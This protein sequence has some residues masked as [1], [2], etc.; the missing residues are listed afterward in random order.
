MK[1]GRILALLLSLSMVCAAL[2]GGTVRAVEGSGDEEGGKTEGMVYHKTAEANGDGTYTI[3]LETYATGDKIITEGEKDKPADIVLVLD[4]SGSMDENM[5][6]YGFREYSRKDNE[7]YYRLRHNNGSQNLYYKTEDGSYISVSVVYKDHYGYEMITNGR[8]NSSG[9]WG[10]QYT[11]YWNNQNNL[12]ARVNGKYQQVTVKRERNGGIFGEY[13]Y[14]YTLPDGTVI[15]RSSG[16]DGNPSFSNIDGNRLYLAVADESQ[17][18]YTYTYTDET[19]KTTEIEISTGKDTTPNTVFYERYM[20]G[21]TKKLEALKTAVTGFVNSVAAKTAGEDGELGTADDVD[22]RIAVVGF[23]SESGY[24]NNT[25]LLSIAGNNSQVGSSGEN[26]GVK[27]GSIEDSHYTQV[28]QD[29][30]TE[31]GRDMVDKAVDALAANGATKSDLGME[32]AK[33]ILEKNPVPDGKER[34]RVVIFFTDGKPTSSNTF[35]TTVA[36][37]TIGYA[38]AI[39]NAGAQVYSVGIFDGADATD[40]GKEPG[41]GWNI[42]DADK[43]NWFMQNVSSNNGTPQDPSYYLSAADSETLNNIFEKISDNIESGGSGTTLDERTVI[44]DVIAESFALPDGADASDISLKT[45]KCT[46]KGADGEYT[47]SENAGGS[48]GARASIAQDGTI[49]VTGFDFAENYVGEKKVNGVTQEYFGN[50]LVISFDVVPKKGFLGGNGVPTNASAGIY[51]NKDQKDPLFTYEV[52]EV[53][54]PIGEVTVETP[55]KNVY[56]LGTVAFDDI[57]D[58]ANVKVGDVTLDLME[59]NFGLESWQ[60][61]YVDISPEYKGANGGSF[62]GDMTGLTGDTSYTVSVEVSPKT[63]GDAEEKSGEDTGSIN[64][65]KPELTFEDSD[66]YYGD[67]APV[68]YADNLTETRWFHADEATDEITYSDSDSVTM[69]GEEP[70]LTMTYKPEEGKIVDDKIAVK[71]DI[72]VDAAVAIGTTDVTGHTTFHHTDCGE[73]EEALPANGKFWLHVKTCDLTVTKQGGANGEPYAFTIYK[74]GKW[75]TGLT[76]VGNGS[77]TI[78]ELPVGIYRI[79]EDE[80]WSWRYTPEYDR[81]SVMLSKANPEG[82]IT[83]TNT[84]GEDSWLNG[85]SGVEAN[86]YGNA[87]SKKGG[88]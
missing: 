36:D 82:S 9:G 40:P 7:D 50:K 78:G 63:E 28:L 22:H 24:G 21:S 61:A 71:E 53:D 1:R 3:Q 6:S 49:E 19:G 44:R 58:K 76:V 31:Q 52:P 35:D 23:A 56:L 42:S 15:A 11:N 5:A 43:C 75:Y 72:P 10:S 70:E 79:E 60:N 13:T 47:W 2:P 14:T 62:V 83:C 33:N 87:K 59:E 8:N 41:T 38:T 37:N 46:G 64:V 77:V 34:S 67:D 55:D 39:K 32:M 86:V 88:R 66:V 69:I 51:E 74:D 25:E 81:E 26:V 45:Y 20:T 4:Q 17:R 27:Y 57:K 16:N 73:G 80:T 48:M 65:Y 30:S 85:Y 84:K 54:V 29:M 68:E 12:Y 18:E